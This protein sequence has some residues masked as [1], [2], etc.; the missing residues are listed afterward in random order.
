MKLTLE[1]L[2]EHVAMMADAVSNE[3][4]KLDCTRSDTST[5]YCISQD[6]REAI[7]D[8]QTTKT[9]DNYWQKRAEEADVEIA[10]L[11][12]IINVERQNTLN[13]V[14][15]RDRARALLDSIAKCLYPSDPLYKEYEEERDSR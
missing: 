11:S 15:Q 2:A 7:S 1:Q 14:E 6:I 5:L 9:E 8:E 3:I 10:R 4:T 13:F 12:T